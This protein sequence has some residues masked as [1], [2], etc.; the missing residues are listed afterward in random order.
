MFSGNYA[1]VVK[2]ITKMN[3]NDVDDIN[4]ANASVLRECIE[5]RDRTS[6]CNSLSYKEANKLIDWIAI[7]RDAYINVIRLHCLLY[8]F[9][10][11]QTYVIIILDANYFT[12]K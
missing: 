1:S 10:T 11:K 4:R 9:C 6:Q 2:L 3:V 12:H 8:V 5:M 7:S